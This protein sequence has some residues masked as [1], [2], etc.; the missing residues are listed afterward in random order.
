MVLFKPFLAVLFATFSCKAVS[1]TVWPVPRSL[2]CEGSP[3]RLSSDFDIESSSESSLLATAIDRY[4]TLIK[5][6][7]ISLSEPRS[8]ERNSIEVVK[9]TTAS[10]DESLNGDTSYEY[11]I[12]VTADGQVSIKGASVYGAMCVDAEEYHDGP[13]H[14]LLPH[15]VRCKHCMISNVIK[16]LSKERLLG[17]GEVLILGMEWRRFLSWL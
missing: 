8:Q 11:W 7:E 15:V 9:V 10:D 14:I 1:E 5:K 12:N 16:C 4:K 2:T 17:V 3:I 13:S 6:Q